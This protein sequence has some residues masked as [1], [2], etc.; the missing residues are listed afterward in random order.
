M[1]IVNKLCNLKKIDNLIYN[2]NCYLRTA[3]KHGSK[4]VIDFLMADESV[5]KAT[6]IGELVNYDT[7]SDIIISIVNQLEIT[8]VIS[9][10]CYMRF[11]TKHNKTDLF[12]AMI[13]QYETLKEIKATKANNSEDVTASE[14]ADDLADPDYEGD[15]STIMLNYINKTLRERE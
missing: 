4:K 13:S 1:D 12:I 11:L 8:S 5:R 3:C 7:S 2:G 6:T 15:T 14:V 10:E 9:M